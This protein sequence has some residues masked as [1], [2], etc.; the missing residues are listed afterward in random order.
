MK[1]FLSKLSIQFILFCATL[2]LLTLSTAPV[3]ARSTKPTPVPVAL[4]GTLIF[5]SN[6]SGSYQIYGK[7]LATGTLTQLTSG[8]SDNLNPESSPNGTN[9][10]FY[11]DRNGSNQIFSVNIATKVVTQLTNDKHG[12][13]DYDPVFSPDGIYIFFKKSGTTGSYGDIYRMTATGAN[14]TDLTPTLTTNRIEGWK[15]TPIS[16]TQIVLTE[17]GKLGKPSTDNLY[18]LDTTTGI[19][20]ALTANTLSNWFP[21]YS[22]TTRKVLFI[23][24]K[25]QGASDV[26]ATMNLDG[27]NRMIIE[28]IAGDNDDPSWSPDGKHIVFINDNAGYYSTYE[29]NSDG[30]V[31]VLADQSPRNTND[32]SPF[33]LP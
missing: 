29:A 21:S 30:T 24:T 22:S 20:T 26:V 5:A 6:R 23:T 12:V 11:S 2:L 25:S 33:L 15:P 9:L 19:M 4:S 18:S 14:Q 1:H 16:D 32:L 8:K 17:R 27:T 13:N 7:N 28:S 3:S 31:P 10:V